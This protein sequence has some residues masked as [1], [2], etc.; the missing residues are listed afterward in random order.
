MRRLALRALL[1]RAYR[2]V[3]RMCPLRTRRPRRPTGSRSGA[4]KG[5]LVSVGRRQPHDLDVMKSTGNGLCLDAPWAIGEEP[6]CRILEALSGRRVRNIIEFGSGL[7]TVRLAQSFPE[8]RILSIEQDPEIRERV[9]RLLHVHEVANAVV[10]HCPL[11]V[12]RIGARVYLSYA[13]PMECLGTDFDFV[14]IDGPIDGMTV[15]GREAP[16]YEVFSLVRIGGL[17]VL[18]DYSRESM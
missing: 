12:L 17:F 2:H 4:G 5:G 15:R 7:S 9:M 13:L 14:L 18:D 11:R 1:R 10:L 8:A 3:N 6:Y 16:L